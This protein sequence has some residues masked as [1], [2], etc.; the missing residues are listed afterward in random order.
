MKFSVLAFRQKHTMFCNQR[1]GGVVVDLK[2]SASSNLRSAASIPPSLW[3]P[4]H[5]GAWFVGRKL[6]HKRYYQ[7]SRQIANWKSNT[8]DVRG[9]FLGEHRQKKLEILLVALYFQISY[10]HKTTFRSRR[11]LRDQVS[12]APTGTWRDGCAITL[13]RNHALPAHLRQGGAQ[14]KEGL[15]REKTC[16]FLP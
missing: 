13:A 4:S 2:F 14:R 3:N 10:S 1:L 16:G 5:L 12:V 9:D 7:S 15:L 11:T 6:S 8:P